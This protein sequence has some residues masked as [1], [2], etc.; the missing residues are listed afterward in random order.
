MMIIIKIIV[1]DCEFEIKKCFVSLAVRNTLDAGLIT[2][3]IIELINRLLFNL[4][5]AGLSSR[6][7]F[8]CVFSKPSV[9]TAV[10]SPGHRAPW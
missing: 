1:R 3:L 9:G 5:V 6:G 8:S 4:C 2:R 10:K 7:C